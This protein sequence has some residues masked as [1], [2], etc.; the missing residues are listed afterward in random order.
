MKK[1]VY[2]GLSLCCLAACGQSKEAPPQQ[3]ETPQA[4]KNMAGDPAATETKEGISPSQIAD[5]APAAVQPAISQE[6]SAEQKGKK[7]YRRCVS[8]H[9]IK[10]DGRHGVGP[11]LWNI[12]AKPA[13]SKPGYRYSTALKE[14]GLIWNDAELDEYLKNPAQMVPGSRMVVTLPKETDR[15]NVIAYIKTMREAQPEE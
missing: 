9:S 6:L 15:A 10:K 1:L 14:A 13:T 5:P 3:V 12:Y 11:N 2:L 8:C 7:L 4:S